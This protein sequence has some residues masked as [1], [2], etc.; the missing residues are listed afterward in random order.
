MKPKTIL[1]AAFCYAAISGLSVFAFAQQAALVIVDIKAVAA[2]VAKNINVQASKIP[3]TVQAPVD[4]A[5]SV[6]RVPANVLRAQGGDGSASCA[7][8]TTSAALE[9]LVRAKLRQQ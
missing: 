7:A 5:A 1:F 8:T 4:V 9:R 2:D 6:C 3:L